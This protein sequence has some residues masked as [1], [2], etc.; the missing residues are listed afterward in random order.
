MSTAGWASCLDTFADHLGHQ[1]Q[2]L[3]EGTPE[4]ITAF[5]P[6]ATLGPL[7]PALLPR[8]RELHSQAEALTDAIAQARVRTLAALQQVRQP[9]EP[10]RPSY[11]DSLA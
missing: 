3:A 11:V 7:P 4:T 9:T 10:A 1:K 2:A 8:A 6:P 5:V